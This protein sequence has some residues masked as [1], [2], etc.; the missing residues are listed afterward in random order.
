MN[1]HKFGAIALGI[2][3]FCATKFIPAALVVTLGPVSIPVAATIGVAIVGLSAVGLAPEK[4]SPTLATI[5]S[6]I[7]IGANKAPIFIAGLLGLSLASSGCAAFK[8]DVK[9]VGTDIAE[10]LKVCKPEMKDELLTAFPFAATFAAC[11]YT[12]G[13]DLSKC[14]AEVEAFKASG[15]DEVRRCALAMIADTSAKIGKL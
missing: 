8:K 13:G 12:N 6:G 9:V 7:K 14:S 15:K 3:S 11:A 4:V 5:L 2:A 10:E 1:W